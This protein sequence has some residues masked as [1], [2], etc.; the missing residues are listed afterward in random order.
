MQDNSAF[1]ITVQLKRSFVAGCDV[2][3]TANINNFTIS[4]AGTI[5]KVRFFI[6]RYGNC[7]KTAHVASSAQDLFVESKLPSEICFGDRSF[8]KL[9][10]QYLRC[11]PALINHAAYNWV[12]TS[13]TLSTNLRVKGGRHVL[14]CI[15]S[16]CFC[17]STRFGLAQWHPQK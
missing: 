2:I 8:V 15:V 9:K 4:L 3:F 12:C 14:T 13:C 10:L 17:I 1:L 11:T 7:I 5:R 16:E 6:P